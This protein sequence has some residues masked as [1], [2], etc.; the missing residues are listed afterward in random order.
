MEIREY[1]E[2]L[3]LTP[4]FVLESLFED[5]STLSRPLN[6][7][8]VEYRLGMDFDAGEGIHSDDRV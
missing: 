7:A 8:S 6:P 4:Y 1:I 5:Y 2:S 3:R